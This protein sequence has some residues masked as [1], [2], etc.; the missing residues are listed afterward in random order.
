MLSGFKRLFG[1]T[2]LCWLAAW[3]APTA[4]G[5]APGLQGEYFNNMT[6]SGVPVLTRIDSTVNFNWGSGSPGA[7]VNANQFSVRWSGQ[8]RIPSNGAYTFYTQS[9][10]GV[11]LWED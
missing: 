9:D 4:A 3:A 10:D 5:V 11:R 8:V 7:G 6:L 1:A 2:A